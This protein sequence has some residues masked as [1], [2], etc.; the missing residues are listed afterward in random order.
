MKKFVLVIFQMICDEL[1]F[2]KCKLPDNLDQCKD[3]GYKAIYARIFEPIMAT[4]QTD[5]LHRALASM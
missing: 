3:G 5:L 2:L 4:N 1:L